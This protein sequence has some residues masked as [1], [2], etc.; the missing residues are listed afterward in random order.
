M[1]NHT[2][3]G[4]NIDALNARKGGVE[5]GGSTLKAWVVGNSDQCRMRGQRKEKSLIA[6]L[7]QLSLTKEPESSYAT[8]PKD[9]DL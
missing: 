1:Q 3:K 6:K 7:R 8:D 4:W 9:W 2:S 5:L